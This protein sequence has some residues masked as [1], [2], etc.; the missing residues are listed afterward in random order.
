MFNITDKQIKNKVRET[1]ESKGFG[2]A[3]EWIAQYNASNRLNQIPYERCEACDT[4]APILNHE[5]LIC[6]KETHVK[7]PVFYQAV[8]K[9]V[10]GNVLDHVYPRFKGT[11][12]QMTLAE[13]LGNEEGCCS[14]CGGNEWMLLAN[15]SVA[16]KQGGKPYIECLTCGST[17]HL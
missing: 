9:K 2:S 6:G 8:L 13:R 16:V 10:K 3:V 11:D 12:E 17:T 5:C 4:Q 1:Y 14:E 15:E 7:K